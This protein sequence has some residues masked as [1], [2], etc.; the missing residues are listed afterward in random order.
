LGAALTATLYI[1]GVVSAYTA[2]ITAGTTSNT[3]D[4]NISINVGQVLTLKWTSTGTA[5]NE[6]SNVNVYLHYQFT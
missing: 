4:T 1:D 2:S 6:G 3:T 5:P